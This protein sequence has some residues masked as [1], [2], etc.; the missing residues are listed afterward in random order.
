MAFTITKQ[1][2]P[3]AVWQEIYLQIQKNGGTLALRKS[4]QTAPLNLALCLHL[5]EDFSVVQIN[6]TRLLNPK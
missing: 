2:R 5:I 4:Q 6:L 1:V 3:N